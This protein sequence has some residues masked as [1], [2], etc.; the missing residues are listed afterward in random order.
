M[1]VPEKPTEESGDVEKAKPEVYADSAYYSEPIRTFLLNNGLNPKICSKRVRNKEMSEEEKS[2]NRERSKIR[3][4]VEHIFGAMYQKAHDQVMRGIGLV[5]ANARI[6][7]R[8]L[9]YNMTRYGYL[10]GAKGV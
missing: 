2:K 5:R 10:S 3:C 8:N 1:S 6:G 4:R 7:L 9:A